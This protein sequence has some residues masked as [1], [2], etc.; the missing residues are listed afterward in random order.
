MF[1]TRL[2]TGIAVLFLA[3]TTACASVAPKYTPLPDNVNRLR[4]AE[5]APVKV[6]EF[7]ADPQVGDAVNQLSIRGGSYS[8][9]YEG[10]YVNY[11]REALRQDLEEARLLNPAAA[12]E[13][14]GVLV[15]NELET[16][17]AKGT[18]S[19]TARFTVKSGG[20]IRFDKTKSATYEWESSFVGAVAIPRAQQNYPIVVQRLLSSLYTDAD[21]IRALKN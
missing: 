15:R 18:A 21:F 9:P 13:V 20:Q 17:T 14:C 3:A 4:D 19:M 2:K 8:S 16:G 7:T 5:A 1:E 11:L 6:A 10:S 12:V